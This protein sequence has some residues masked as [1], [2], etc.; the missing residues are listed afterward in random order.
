MQLASFH[1]VRN[2]NI[3]VDIFKSSP[4]QL[5]FSFIKYND[6]VVNFENRNDF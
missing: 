4:R 5:K 2:Q 3:S 6:S 1:S